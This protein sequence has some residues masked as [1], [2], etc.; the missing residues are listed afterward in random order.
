MG[1]LR[2]RE[3]VSFLFLRSEVLLLG[4]RKTTI[5]VVRA[6]RK[7]S[8]DANVS[9]GWQWMPRT[10]ALDGARDGDRM[11][12]NLRPA[13]MAAGEPTT[14]SSRWPPSRRTA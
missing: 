2:S 9:Y 12:H 4:P 13:K 11:F 3:I 14:R 5:K 8:R 1:E 10:D 7:A 6:V